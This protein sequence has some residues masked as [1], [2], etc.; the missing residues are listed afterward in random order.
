VNQ[1]VKKQLSELIDRV[2]SLSMETAEITKEQGNLVDRMSVIRAERVITIAF[3]KD[4]KGKPISLAQS[5]VL[6]RES[7]G[8]PR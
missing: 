4:D 7:P 2:A 6:A 3:A 1:D 8:R 5:A